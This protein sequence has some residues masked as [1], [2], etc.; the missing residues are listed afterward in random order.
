MQES[1]KFGK[2]QAAMDTLNRSVT[3]DVDL[4]KKDTGGVF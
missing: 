2:R 1:L 3:A 4:T